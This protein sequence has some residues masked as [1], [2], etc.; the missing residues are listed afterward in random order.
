MNFSIPTDAAKL[1]WLEKVAI[2]GHLD[3]STD[4]RSTQGFGIWHTG[5]ASLLLSEAKSAANRRYSGQLLPLLAA[6]SAMDQFGNCYEPIAPSIPPGMENKSGI[7]KA[8]HNFL[9]IPIG[10]PDSDA[11]YALRN[12]LLHQSGLISAGKGRVP[13]HYWFA[14]DTESQGLFTHATVPW[15][16][17]YNSRSATNKTVA[18]TRAIFNL[19]YKLNTKLQAA[20]DAGNLK[21]SLDG[22]LEELLRSYVSIEFNESLDASYKQ[23]QSRQ[24]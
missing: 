23:S 20:F 3:I 2:R 15:D 13:K 16:G 21:L 10:S 6:L 19:A 17:L 8:L 14:I 5:T 9:G 11:I 24:Q 4:G 22:G 1:S 7:I 18:N 12:S